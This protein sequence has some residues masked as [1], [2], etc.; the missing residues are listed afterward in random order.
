MHQDKRAGHARS[1]HLQVRLVLALLWG[2]FTW[3]IGPLGGWVSS[4]GWG[5]CWMK[6]GLG[7]RRAVGERPAPYRIHPDRSRT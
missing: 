7:P 6:V 1:A 2:W 5:E 3:V 4:E